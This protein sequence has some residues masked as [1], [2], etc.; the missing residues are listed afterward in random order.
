MFLFILLREFVTVLIDFSISRCVFGII[1][2]QLQSVSL[3]GLHACLV[4][5]NWFRK[6]NTVD[7]S[8]IIF[9]YSI[10]ACEVYDSVV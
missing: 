10:R 7:G 1:H 2:Y 8:L 4:E 6:L 3:L 9:N 5:L